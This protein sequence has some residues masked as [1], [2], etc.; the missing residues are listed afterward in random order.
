MI[1]S[2]PNFRIIRRIGEGGFGSVWLA[3]SVTGKLRAVKWVRRECFE[4]PGLSPTGVDALFRMEFEGVQRFEDLAAKT[5][6]LV[7]IQVVGKIDAAAAY[8]YVMPLADN[9]R[10]DADDNPENY[11]PLTLHRW[12]A[13]H[14]PMPWDVAIELIATIARG[15]AALHRAGLQHGDISSDNI[16]FI[17]GRWV[18]ADPGLTSLEGDRVA[19]H[20][21]GFSDPVAKCRDCAGGCCDVFA[22]GRILYHA[23]SG[24]HPAESFPVV[25]PEQMA[26]LPVQPFSEFLDLCCD[27]DPANRFANP[28][29]LLAW[30]QQQFPEHISPHPAPAIRRWL[31]KTMVAMLAVLA[32]A[33]IWVYSAWPQTPDPPRYGGLP[34]RGFASVP[35]LL[36]QRAVWRYAMVASPDQ[37]VPADAWRCGHGPFH[38]GPDVRELPERLSFIPGKFGQA[39]HFDQRNAGLH[40]VEGYVEMPYITGE[41]TIALWV[42][43][44]GDP[45]TTHLSCIWS[46]GILPEPQL[47]LAVDNHLRVYPAYSGEEVPSVN[48]QLSAVDM[49]DGQWRHLAVTVSRKRLGFYVDGK[50]AGEAPFAADPGFI[51]APQFL[52]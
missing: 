19:G 28:D 43:V 12:L 1:P 35:E 5:P 9:A 52:G 24:K 50:L 32:G 8:Y 42:R 33:G 15:A 46:L 18:L 14:G 30:L 3:E 36:P 48:L 17:D 6:E 39:L 22:L 38:F 41:F 27:P 45:P 13:I 20:S 29:A 34:T 44:D 10:P 51:D 26:A 31:V 25:P 11:T 4:Q 2:I 40:T 47:M 49:S 7:S 23:V 37:P 21:P 16:L